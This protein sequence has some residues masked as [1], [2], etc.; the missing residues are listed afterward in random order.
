[1]KLSLLTYLLGK[2]YKLDELLEICARYGYR[3]V[4][5][6]AQLGHK[7]GIELETS[8]EERAAIK[9]RL[10]ASPVKLVGISTGCRF[11]YAEAEKVREQVE[12]AKRFVDLA[13]DVGAPQIRVFGN[14]FPK[15]AD[16][17]RVVK[18]VGESLREIAEHAE[19]SGVDCNL[20]MHGDF[21]HWKHTLRAVQIADHPRV[22]IVYNCDARE[23]KWGPIRAFI[24]PVAPYLRHV[25]M[26]NLE[27]DDYPYP[28]LFRILKD[29]GYAGY[30][31]LE[32]GESPDP[33][34]C[35]ALYA[36]LFTWMY[37]NV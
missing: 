6:R 27:R 23:T 8:P 14:A 5:C 32:C 15:G 36:R 31:S 26:H 10:A 16:R 24:D 19:P 13:A 11:E 7:H 17:D 18:Q 34:R 3:G 20:E 12:I 22:G 4:E 35:I 25:H 29:L 28:E 30:L 21:Y 9:A 1:M 33:E 37:W 2:D